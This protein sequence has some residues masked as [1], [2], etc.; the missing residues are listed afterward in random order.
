[1]IAHFPLEN[2][3]L[4]GALPASSSRGRWLSSS[5]RAPIARLAWVV[6]IALLAC[7][8]LPAEALCS[9]VAQQEVKVEVKYH[10]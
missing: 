10:L 1:M 4:A 3:D 9:S 6:V 2:E 5:A 8:P 7:S